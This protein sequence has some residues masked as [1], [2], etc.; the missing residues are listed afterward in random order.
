[1]PTTTV[2]GTDIGPPC[3]CNGTIYLYVVT[4]TVEAKCMGCHNVTTFN[5]DHWPDCVQVIS[6]ENMR[7]AHWRSN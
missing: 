5:F 4:D 2:T 7:K 6:G 1:M 3:K